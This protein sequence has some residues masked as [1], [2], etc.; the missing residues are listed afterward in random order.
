MQPLDEDKSRVRLV[1]VMQEMDRRGLNHGTAGNVSARVEGGFLV[2]P[3]GIPASQLEPQSMVK[4]DPDG[5]YDGRYKPTSEWQMHATLLA[6]RP[7]MN[8]VLHCHSRYA[9]ILACAHHPIPPLH[10]M[11]AVT[12]GPQIEIAPYATFGTAE[13][14]EKIV[15][16]LSGRYG[17]LMANH[18]QIAVAPT[19]DKALLIASEI[20]EQAAVYH[21]TLAIGGPKLLSTE[22]IQ[23]VMM[24]FLSYGQQTRD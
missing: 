8:A 16:T 24:Q 14:A 13:L 11:T 9:T 21:G 17:C 4:I 6:A 10:Y 12:G 20:E 5:G 22:Q 1:D 15:E 18:G 7:E 19:I 3:S 23:Q 2:S